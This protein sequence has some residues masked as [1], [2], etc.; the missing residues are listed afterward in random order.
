ME[1]PSLFSLL[2]FGPDGWGMR[3]VEGLVVTVE[4]SV[5]AYFI[6]LVLGLIGAGAKLSNSKV[7]RGIA[8]IYTTLVRAL[9]E[10][11]LLLLIYFSG[12]DAI[13]FILSL[14]SEDFDDFE[15]NPFA[16]AVAALGFIGGAY[17]TEVMR[18]AILSI[19]NGQIEAAKACGMSRFLTLRRVILPQMLRYALP[20]MGNLWLSA[21]KDSSLI[22]VLGNTQD[23]LFMGYRASAV[24]KHYGF[25]Y[26]V[27]AILFLVITI[28]SMIVIKLLE[29]RVNRG[30]R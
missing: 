8:D 25:F 13:K 20:G 27:A 18:G 21:T 9:P 28:V 12:A 17:M 6:S 1:S 5:A 22:S 23:L 19:P 4:V 14:I 24:T 15:I 7:A 2:S 11:L 26:S 3:F 10:L 16:A 30:Y 29:A